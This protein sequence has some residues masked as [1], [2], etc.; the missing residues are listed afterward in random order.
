MRLI[1]TPI[2]DF[3]G[4]RAIIL[5]WGAY[6]P[7]LDVP[8]VLILFLLAAGLAWALYNWTHPDVHS[9]R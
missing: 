8:G 2:N 5:I 4:F 9:H 6:M 1:K 3:R 7:T